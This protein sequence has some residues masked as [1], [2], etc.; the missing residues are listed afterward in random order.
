MAVTP[1]WAVEVRGGVRRPT[2][3]TT[4]T[5]DAE[6][7]G[8]FTATEDVAEYVVD[9]SVLYHPSWAGLGL[10][11]AGVPPGRRRVSAPT[12]RR[13]RAGRDR[14]D[15]PRRCRH[16]AVVGRRPWPRPRSRPDRR[17]P[18]GGPPR[19]DHLR[20]GQA[21]AAGRCRCGRSWDSETAMADLALSAAGVSKRFGTVVALDDVSLEVA[22]RRV[23]GAG[24]GERVGQE[25]A[26]ARVQRPDR[27]RRRPRPRR[28]ARR[29][30][31]PIRWRVR[32]ALGYVPQDGGLLPHWTVARN[33][34]LVPWLLGR[35]DPAGDAE[36]GAGHR[37]AAGAR[38][39]PSAGRTS[40][41]ADSASAWPSRGRWPPAPARCCSTSRSARST[42]S[43]AAT[44]RR[45]SSTCG[46]TSG[47][48]ALLVTH[49]LHEA[50]LL[51]DRVAVMHQG[52]LAQVDRP[53][54]LVARPATPYVADLLTRARLRH[55]AGVVSR[56]HVAV[57][58]GV[59]AAAIAAPVCAGAR[60]QQPVAT[61]PG[62]PSGRHR[63]EAV[64]RVV[65]AG[66]ALRPDPRGARHR[67]DAGASGSA[68]PRSCS[69]RCAAAPSTSF[70]STPARACW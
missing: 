24:R 70:P 12:P 67:G 14:L 25:H 55:G 13:Q 1:G 40:C 7:A 33:V 8:T 6:A 44:C 47:L 5:S 65:P 21:L 56:G 43:P 35:P 50:A 10:A 11:G 15:R 49:D 46:A 64:R 19:W 39:S 59:L 32:R 20:R 4:I 62:R 28:R 22:R 37:R 16:A 29:W 3:T 54:V 31:R 53:D 38:S 66:R 27:D 9:A 52:R 69:R 36:R 60:R 26:A 18:L 58:A 48:S 61:V 68:A 45:C 2:L 30:P 41:R 57:A 63:L 23:R 17:R 34:A 42:R 51:A